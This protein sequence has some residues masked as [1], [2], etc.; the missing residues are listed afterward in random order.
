MRE[1][2]RVNK[3]MGSVNGGFSCRFLTLYED[4]RGVMCDSLRPE[5]GVSDIEKNRRVEV[6][7]GWGSGKEFC[8]EVDRDEG[9][10]LFVE[11]K[12]IGS[13]WNPM[14]QQ[15]KVEELFGQEVS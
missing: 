11:L 7:F 8:V 12:K 4:K 3:E 5:W 6:R 13:E 2:W 15:R 9:N 10:R 14:V 1:E